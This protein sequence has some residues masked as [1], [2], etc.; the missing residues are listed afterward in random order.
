[1]TESYRNKSMVLD[2]QFYTL[3]LDAVRTMIH[4]QAMCKIARVQPTW[5]PM[6]HDAMDR[7]YQHSRTV[8]NARLDSLRESRYDYRN[9]PCYGNIH[10]I[11]VE[12]GIVGY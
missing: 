7:D 11:M 6:V 3:F 1:M 9:L 4:R 2:T 8:V 12:H 10:E 5:Q